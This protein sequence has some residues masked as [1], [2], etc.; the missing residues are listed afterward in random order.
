MFFG[1]TQL[2][3]YVCHVLPHFP[4]HLLLSSHCPSVV[5]IFAL[6]V[7]DWWQF[8]VVLTLKV[9]WSSKNDPLCFLEVFSGM[10][11]PSSLKTSQNHL[12]VSKV[13]PCRCSCAIYP[14]PT[15]VTRSLL[16]YCSTLCRSCYQHCSLS[17]SFRYST[18]QTRAVHQRAVTDLA[19]GGQ[20]SS[21][22]VFFDDITGSASRPHITYRPRDWDVIHYHCS[23]W[24][25]RPPGTTLVWSIYFFNGTSHG[26]VLI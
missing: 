7:P 17:C 9:L 1:A 13:P 21:H 12:Q 8:F 22:K 23:L 24:V 18:L 26:T 10:W 15:S 6:T 3:L 19:L 20:S 16:K 14:S 4:F 11:S 2:A 5:L 25:R